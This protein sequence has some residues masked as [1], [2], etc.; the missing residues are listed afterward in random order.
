MIYLSA[1]P[2]TLFYAWQVEVMI[3]NFLRYDINPSD[4]HILI[5]CEPKGLTTT[6]DSIISWGKLVKNYKDVNFFFYEDTRKTKH[7][8]SSIRPNIIKQ[9]FLANREI[10]NQTM[11]YHDCDM[12]FTKKPD[13]SL[14]ERDDVWYLSNTNSYINYDYIISKGVDIYKKM[15][16]IVGIS[17][18]LPRKMNNESGGAQYIMKNTDFDFW[19]KVEHDSERLYYEISKINIEKK[20]MHPSYHELQIWCADMWAVLWNSWLIGCKTKVVDELNFCWPTE[21]NY[22]WSSHYIYH[23]AGVLPESKGLFNKIEFSGKIPYDIQLK[24]YD[25][26]FCSYNYV[27]EILNTADKSCLR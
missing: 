11:F 4:I 10:L 5:S 21:Y 13:L 26:D 18:E 8:V 6:R 27:M 7:Y 25:T 16:D 17:E 24:D 22:K 19:N 23:N 1:Q 3:N 20:R 15:C 2:R 12:I 9:H 14:Y